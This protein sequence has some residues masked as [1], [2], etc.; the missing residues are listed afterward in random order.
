MARVAYTVEPVEFGSAAHLALHPYAKVPAMQ[1]GDVKLYE[2]SAICHYVDKAFN[3]PSLQ[4]SD[5][6]AAGLM[7]Q[8]ISMVN[9][10]IYDDAIKRYVLQYIFPKG[11]DGQ[12]DRTAIDAALPD[13]ER[14]LDQLNDALGS[15]IHIVGDALSLAD[16][17][18]APILFY[19]SQFPESGEMIQARANIVRAGGAMHDRPSF[20]AT[21]PPAPPSD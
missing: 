11:A 18:V 19:L 14:D 6:N 1:H 13:I 9:C 8:W 16:L 15:G 3:G 5:A 12:P 7:E 4:P 20:Q 17:F 10:Y 2:T 21:M